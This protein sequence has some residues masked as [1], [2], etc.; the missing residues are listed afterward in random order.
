MPFYSP[1]SSPNFEV[2]GAFQALAS[3]LL[4]PPSVL[5]LRKILLITWLPPELQGG[6]FVVF[7]T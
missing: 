3:G 7:E 6:G 1:T 2:L 4:H 5:P